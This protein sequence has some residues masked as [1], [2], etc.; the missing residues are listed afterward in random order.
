MTGGEFIKRIRRPGRTKG[1]AVRLDKK[2]GRSSHVT[3]YFRDRLTVVRSPKG[4]LKTGTLH[5]MEQALAAL[6]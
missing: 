1:M 2:R 3:L 6:G 5:A 4:E